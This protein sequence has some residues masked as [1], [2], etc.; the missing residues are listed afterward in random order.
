M[1]VPGSI[2]VIDTGDLTISSV[3]S[4]TIDYTEL[5]A[6]GIVLGGYSLK[7]SVDG[8]SYK[9][10]SLSMK[11]KAYI[12]DDLELNAKSSSFL[13]NGEYYGYNYASTDNRTYTSSTDAVFKDGVG[14]DGQA[15]Y[16]SSAIILNGEN[17]N[18]DLSKVNSLYIA[19]QSYIELAKETT[20]P[21]EGDKLTYTITNN[22]G[23]DVTFYNEE[24]KKNTVSYPDLDADEYYTINDDNE[25]EQVN[26]YQTGEAVS[27]KSNQLA[28]IPN[29]AVKY[30]EDNEYYYISIPER[31]EE[32]APY[33]DIWSDLSK[34]PVVKTMVSG[35]EYHY[36]D[37]SKVDKSLTDADGNVV[38]NSDGDPVK[39]S[40]VQLMRE[41]I[42]QYANLFTTTDEDD[43]NFGKSLGLKDITDYSGFKVE[44]LKL[45]MDDSEENTCMMYLYL[46]EDDEVVYG[47]EEYTP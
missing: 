39:V 8:E 40:K 20:E 3:E 2:A 5:W 45:K 32:V 30:D 11:A 21:E 37:F 44:Q 36:F 28:Y 12:A 43:N 34:V 4:A 15:H 7:N 17:S 38:Y 19:G 27:V 6:D 41:F 13:M 46:N 1:I 29:W 10:A 9:G 25:K 18:L 31:L 26:N 23:D 16:N 22:D 24:V 35:K 47:F 14:I 33:K 42:E